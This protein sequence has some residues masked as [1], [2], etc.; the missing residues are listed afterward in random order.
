MTLRTTRRGKTGG[1]VTSPLLSQAASRR[2]RIVGALVV[3]VLLIAL[4]LADAASAPS[5]FAQGGLGTCPNGTTRTLRGDTNCDGLVRLAV[6]GDGLVAGEGAGSYRAETMTARN[7]CHRS[8]FAWSAGVVSGLPVAEVINFD[9]AANPAVLSSGSRAG[10]SAMLVAAC[11]G[12]GVNNYLSADDSVDLKLGVHRNQPAQRDQLRA[13]REGG[14][15]DAVVV[16]FGAE[17]ARFADVLRLCIVGNCIES[18]SL[19]ETILDQALDAAHRVKQVLADIKAETST[20]NQPVAA[21]IYVSSFANPMATLPMPAVCTFSILPTTVALPELP[22]GSWVAP[23]DAASRGVSLPSVVGGR[24]AQQ[25][26]AATSSAQLSFNERTFLA[27]RFVPELNFHLERAAREIGLNYVNVQSAL[28]GRSL[29]DPSPLVHRVGTTIDPFNSANALNPE[30]LMPTKDGHQLLATAFAAAAGTTLGNNP[31]DPPAGRMS[32][33]RPVAR[34]VVTDV[35]GATGSS[36]RPPSAMSIEVRTAKP[37]TTYRVVLGRV[38]LSLVTLQTNATGFAAARFPLPFSMPPGAQVL[39]LV[40][41]TTEEAVAQE[42]VT[43]EPTEGCPATAP[44]APGN[45]DGDLLPDSCDPSR[46]DG[47]TADYDGDGTINGLDNCP[48]I[49]GGSSD[50]D[51]D[52]VGNACDSSSGA[53]LS[54]QFV[55]VPNAAYQGVAPAR[56]VDTRPGERTIDGVTEGIGRRIAGSTLRVL[57][58]GRGGVPVGAQTVAVNLTAVTPLGPGHFTV[59]SCLGVRPDASNLNYATGAVIANSAFV[60][61]DPDGAFCI[62]TTTE[63]HVVIDVNGFVPVGADFTGRPPARLYESRFGFNTVDGREQRTGTRPAGSVTTITVAGRG[64]VPSGVGAVK[65]NVT[66]TGPQSNGHITIFPCDQTQ[67]DA[68]NLNYVAGQT[69]ANSVTANV[70]ASGTV[71]A[72]TTTPT[73]LIIDVQGF[74][75]SSRGFVS[76]QPGRVLETRVGFGSTVDGQFSAIG[77]R[78]SLSTTALV[79]RGRAGVPA[80]AAAVVVNVTI[81]DPSAP[82]FVTV[83]PCGGAVPQASNVNYVAGQTIANSVTVAVGTSGSVCLFTTA[84]AH[85][86]VDVNG[87]VRSIGPDGLFQN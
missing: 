87:A 51:I 4:I 34:I 82:G 37:S 60:D 50:A 13:F 29:C 25:I 30:Q 49:A 23:L 40:D 11:S 7:R 19:Q 21:E 61:L 16:G 68:S 65:L 71:C 20:P 45:F 57:A 69:I 81:T 36:F 6:L 27:E 84:A 39:R 62:F 17:D 47:P 42:I 46:F 12:V 86:I 73:E 35:Q 80:T 63:T 77:K 14:A 33:L 1:V 67:P 2:P 70:S 5:A 43:I 15:I 83:Y 75:G 24:S 79:V 18:A 64:G 56:L 22:F 52:D 85:L 54:A 66:V 48:L 72:F 58:A 74:F 76:L 32:D 59:S 31:N 53:P 28:S 55:M 38:P 44:T 78:T 3:G 8:P 26:V 41:T 10:Q 9:P